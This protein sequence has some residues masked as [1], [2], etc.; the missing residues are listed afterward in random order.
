VVAQ[1]GKLT[2]V[3]QKRRL[4]QL[5][6]EHMGVASKK[7]PELIK[8]RLMVA[9]AALFSVIFITGVWFSVSRGGDTLVTFQSPVVYMNRDPAMEIVK[10]SVNTVSLELEGS[11]ALI[12]AI[13]PDQV[14]VK[15]DMSNAKT[16][17]NSFTITRESISLPPGI[18]LKDVKPAVVE[19]ELDVL[20]KKELPVQIDWVGKLPDNLILAQAGLEP[21]SVEI[22]GGK[23]ILGNIST[24]YTEKVPLNNLDS[25]GTITVNLALTP[26]SLKIAPNSKE[27][28]T[29]KY[30]TSLRSQ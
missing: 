16:G 11:G 7:G 18:V 1:N 5:L 2:T 6:Q 25:K 23:R 10:T 30:S 27:K 15:L 12:K 17:L 29:I 21:K 13:K 19:V 14:Q 8:E 20:I 28:V 4:E 22:I 9:A 26:A 24:I 3:R